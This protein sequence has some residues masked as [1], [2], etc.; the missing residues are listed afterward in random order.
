VSR[1]PAICWVTCTRLLFF[2]PVVFTIVRNLPDLPHSTQRQI[3]AG[4]P[5]AEP[6]ETRNSKK[7]DFPSSANLEAQIAAQ[8]IRVK[9]RSRPPPSHESCSAFPPPRRLEAMV[10]GAAPQPCPPHYP[11]AFA[12]I[13]PPCSCSF[14]GSQPFFRPPPMGQPASTRRWRPWP[15]GPEKIVVGPEVGRDSST[16]WC[17]LLAGVSFV[18]FPSPVVAVATIFISSWRLIFSHTAPPPTN[19]FRFHVTPLVSPTAEGDLW[20]L[21]FYLCAVF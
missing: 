19:S 10:L 11:S 16:H 21:R 5:V 1:N 9:P 3:E 7:P 4:F 2:A 15:P 13:V 12:L 6:S 8:Q 18:G 17:R 14:L 20:F